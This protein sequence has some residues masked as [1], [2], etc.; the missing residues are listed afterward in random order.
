[1]NHDLNSFFRS[2]NISS[3]NLGMIGTY[4]IITL[5]DLVLNNKNAKSNIFDATKEAPS[6]IKQWSIQVKHDCMLF[7]SSEKRKKWLVQLCICDII[8][9]CCNV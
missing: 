9:N 5:A 4:I 1:M 6:N 3:F 7:T 8:C 2:F